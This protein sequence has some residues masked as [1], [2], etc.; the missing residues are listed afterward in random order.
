MSDDSQKRDHPLKGVGLEVKGFKSF[1]S[2]GARI[3]KFQP[4]NIF[5]GKNNSGKSGFIDAIYL[6]TKKG[7][8]F[9]ADRH[10]RPEIP[11]GI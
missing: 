8:T 10:G 11:F 5:I 3:E 7:S 1:G 2:K 4:I 9:K 6:C